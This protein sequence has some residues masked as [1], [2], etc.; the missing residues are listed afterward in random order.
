MTTLIDLSQDIKALKP[1][2]VAPR[3][4]LHQLA[5]A[6]QAVIQ[7][8]PFWASWDT[9][10]LKISSPTPLLTD[11]STL[12]QRAFG[13]ILLCHSIAGHF[14]TWAPEALQ[15]VSWSQHLWLT[16]V[17]SQQSKPSLLM[18]SQPLTPN[19]SSRWR[20]SSFPIK[21]RLLAMPGVL[22]SS[23]TL[24]CGASRNAM[25]ISGR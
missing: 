20:E 1:G 3:R 15:R 12:M 25:P 21:A 10:M 24:G 17:Q 18:P 11:T 8:G 23:S 16:L 9:R 22:G 19:P 7:R 5:R 14:S 6:G 4:E 13:R 2:L